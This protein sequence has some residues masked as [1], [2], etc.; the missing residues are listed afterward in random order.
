ML[1]FEVSS[2]LSDR[3]VELHTLLLHSLLFQCATG[4]VAGG[5]SGLASSSNLQAQHF[6]PSQ[7]ISSAD[8]TAYTITSQI[9]GNNGGY[10]IPPIPG[11]EPFLY[12]PNAKDYP[13]QQ[14]VMGA[15]EL[16]EQD[17]PPNCDWLQDVLLT[18]PANENNV[19]NVELQVQ[20]SC[21]NYLKSHECAITKVMSSNVYHNFF[22]ESI[23]SMVCS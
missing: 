3:G 7:T 20:C 18:H 14:E 1:D 12:P 11:E 8:G 15:V 19:G 4:K 16:M 22:A 9:D 2:L 23:S 5:S 17:P 6:V 10:I 21:P 13:V